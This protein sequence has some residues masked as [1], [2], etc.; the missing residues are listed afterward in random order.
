MWIGWPVATY[1]IPRSIKQIAGIKIPA[2]KPTLVII[3]VFF[4]PPNWEK[5]II[6]KITTI[7]TNLIK[8][9]VDSAGNP[10]K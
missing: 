3:A 9:F 8:G 4:V 1:H 5:T 10:N 2:I 7:Q 6:Q